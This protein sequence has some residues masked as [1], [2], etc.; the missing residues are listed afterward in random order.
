M[1][2]FY[3]QKI[4]P[5]FRPRWKSE[6][7]TLH[8]SCEYQV[9]LLIFCVMPNSQNTESARIF[10]FFA[11]SIYYIS[12]RREARKVGDFQYVMSVSCSYFHR[13]FPAQCYHICMVGFVALGAGKMQDLL[14]FDGSS[15][16]T[17]QRIIILL[18][19]YFAIIEI[20]NQHWLYHKET[21]QSSPIRNA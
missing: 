2:D 18:W 6:L 8:H 9:F 19:T 10:P 5:E 11:R 14:R 7:H 20:N 21:E 17:H 15:I 4:Q 12:E 1:Y 3:Y 13:F 16:S